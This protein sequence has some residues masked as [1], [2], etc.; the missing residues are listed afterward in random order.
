MIVRV[1]EKGYL[2]ERATSLHQPRVARYHQIQ[3]SIKSQ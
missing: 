3:T 2:R 1:V